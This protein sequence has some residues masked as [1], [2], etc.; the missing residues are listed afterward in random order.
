M[1]MLKVKNMEFENLIDYIFDKS[2]AFQEFF[3]QGKTLNA[4]ISKDGRFLYVNSRWQEV[5][6]FTPKELTSVPL[7]TFVHRDDLSKCESIYNGAK[8][9]LRYRTRNGQ[10][11]RVK[12]I[13]TSESENKKYWL[14]TG[15]VID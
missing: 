11:K 8:K 2:E 3:S 10:F 4:I 5:L 13:T 9:T 1:N 6:G 7:K 12:W 14:A 15:L